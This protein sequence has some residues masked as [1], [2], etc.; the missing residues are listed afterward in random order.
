MLSLDDLL[1]P[2]TA[3]QFHAEIDDRKPLHIP[4]DINAPKRSIFDWTQFNALLDQDSLWTPQSLKL[5][6]NGRPVEPES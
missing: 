1:Q 6:V 4:A 5:V 3:D 2:V